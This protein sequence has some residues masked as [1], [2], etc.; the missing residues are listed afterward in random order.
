MFKKKTY[1]FYAD[2]GHGWLKV[3]KSDLVELGIEN[4]ITNYSFENGDYAFL[5]E[6]SDTYRFFDAYRK[7]HNIVNATRLS[8]VFNIKEHKSNYSRIRSY[9][10]YKKPMFIQQGR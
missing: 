5:E 1:H 8:D 10:H 6:D 2:N 7:K 3:K 4:E 9:W